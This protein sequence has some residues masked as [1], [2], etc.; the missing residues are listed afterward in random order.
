M[1]FHVDGVAQRETSILALFWTIGA[2]GDIVEFAHNIVPFTVTHLM[3]WHD[4]RPPTRARRGTARTVA[5]P[6]KRGSYSKAS[7][8]CESGFLRKKICVILSAGS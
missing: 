7:A 4:S 5:E 8:W 6:G 1:K 3:C 2:P